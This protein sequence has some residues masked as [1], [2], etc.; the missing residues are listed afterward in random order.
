MMDATLLVVKL[1]H[2]Y[3]LQQ[4]LTSAQPPNL[5]LDIFTRFFQIGFF[6]RTRNTIP[7]DQKNFLQKYRFFFRPK[8]WKGFFIVLQFKNL[9]TFGLV[10]YTIKNIL[11]LRSKIDFFEKIQGREEGFRI[12]SHFFRDFF[13]DPTQTFYSKVSQRLQFSIFGIL[14]IFKMAKI[15]QKMKKKPD[16][17]NLDVV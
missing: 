8:I 12:L 6:I 5:D 17:S 10:I 7:L 2:S 13:M 14:E 3:L 1:Y 16:W 4:C 15:V 11:T 9:L